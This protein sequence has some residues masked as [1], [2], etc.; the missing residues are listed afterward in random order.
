VARLQGPAGPARRGRGHAPDGDAERHA[1]AVA[2]R[3]SAPGARLR[4]CRA[5]AARTGC[6]RPT[7][8]TS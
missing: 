1:R 3:R 8:T 4:H 6:R 5:S 2:R 7:I